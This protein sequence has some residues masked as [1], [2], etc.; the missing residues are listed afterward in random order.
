M[1]VPL[2]LTPYVDTEADVKVTPILGPLLRAAALMMNLPDREVSPCPE[3][4]F[5]ILNFVAR[6]YLKPQVIFG[7][8]ICLNDQCTVFH[9]TVTQGED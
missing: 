6:D 3:C 7:G 4:G 8:S 5:M 9:I 2:H 1:T